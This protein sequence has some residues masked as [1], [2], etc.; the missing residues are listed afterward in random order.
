[1][2]DWNNFLNELKVAE[3]E[4]GNPTEIW[5]RGQFDCS[6]GLHPSLSRCVDWERKEKILFEEF[7]R[8]S[9]GVFQT[10]ANDW[11]TLFDMQHY[12]IPTRLL[13][14]TT[15]LGVALAFILHSD[16]SNDSDSAIYVLDPLALNRLSG[17][18]EVI[19]LPDDPNFEYKKTYWENRPVKIEK[20]LAIQPNYISDRLKAQAGRF[21]VFGTMEGSFEN[22]AKDCFRKIILPA[23]AKEEARIFLK[24]ANLNEFTIY[25]D[26]VGIA[27]HIKTKIL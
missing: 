8:L 17:R 5:Y 4:L 22:T 9:I 14:W 21:T 25:P 10:R 2:S 26:M 20:P 27:N 16:F 15:V 18:D 6:W 12:W 7:K 11:E 23:S 3:D 24:W 13:D 19:G 1:M